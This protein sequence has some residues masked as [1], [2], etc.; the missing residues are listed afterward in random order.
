MPMAVVLELYKFS[1]SLNIIKSESEQKKKNQEYY[2][3]LNAFMF[4]LIIQNSSPK[5]G[6]ITDLSFRLCY[7]PELENIL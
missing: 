5:I 7:Q 3:K 6:R 4:G 1:I 2:E